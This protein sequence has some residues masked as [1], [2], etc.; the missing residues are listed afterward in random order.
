MRNILILLL[1]MLTWG[2]SIAKESFEGI[3]QVAVKIKP[4]LILKSTHKHPFLKH[5]L[6]S[7]NDWQLLKSCPYP[8]MLVKHSEQPV[9]K[10]V[11]AA[12]DPE[13]ELSKVNHLDDSVIKQARLISNSLNTNLEVCNCFDSTPYELFAANAMVGGGWG[14]YLP[15]NYTDKGDMVGFFREKNEKAVLQY[16]DTQSVSPE[17]CHIYSG[18]PDK[19]LIEAVKELDPAVLVLGTT[20]RTG[21]LG[22][23]AEK[24]LDKVECDILAVKYDG[25]ESP[26]V[27]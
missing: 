12:I 4:Q 13:H 2:N 27:V 3:I 18:E 14:M 16:L 5:F 11:L 26:A 9:N 23:T 20:Y 1:L 15:A 21:L 10:P 8:L 7:S 19:G 6:F 24:V 17:H 22:S 25:F